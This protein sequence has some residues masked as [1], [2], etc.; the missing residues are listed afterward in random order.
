VSDK[1]SK[2]AFGREIVSL[3]L[4]RVGEEVNEAILIEIL[5]DRIFRE[6]CIQDSYSLN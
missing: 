3:G 2:F 5:F 6:I 1:S 4:Y